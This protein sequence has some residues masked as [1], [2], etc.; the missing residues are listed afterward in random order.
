M[1]NPTKMEI[2]IDEDGV[3]SL[4]ARPKGKKEEKR[5]GADESQLQSNDEEIREL[6][7]DAEGG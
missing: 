5:D 6:A 3:E 7:N 2:D 4:K 1:G